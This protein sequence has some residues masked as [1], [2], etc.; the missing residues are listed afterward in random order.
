M[1]DLEHA[2][3]Q[4]GAALRRIARDLVGA[5][6]AEDV[7]QETALQALQA[8]SPAAGAR[9]GFLFTV[10]RRMAFRHRRARLRR[11]A[12]EAEVARD[13]VEH[14]EGATDHGEALRTLT[15]AVV[16][17][18]EPYRGAVYARY[19]QEQA[20]TAIAAALGVP[21]GTV[22]TRLK[23]GL[24]M[25]R[26]RLHARCRERGEDWRSGLVLAFALP[27]ATTST[28]SMAAAAAGGVVMTM[29]WK[30]LAAT[31]TVAALA[32]WFAMSPPEAPLWP[33]AADA[34]HVAAAAQRSQVADAD[35]VAAERV[36]PGAAAS[37][38][39]GDDTVAQAVTV[40]G[41]CV[42]AGGAPLGDVPISCFDGEE[43]GRSVAS[44]RTAVD[45]TFAWTT[46]SL[47]KGGELMLGRRGLVRR[48][49][50]IAAVV[51]PAERDLGDLV[52]A[53]ACHVLGRIVDAE[54]A[55]VP[56]LRIAFTAE[57]LGYPVGH[58]KAKS[59]G[60]FTLE[61][62]LP[63]GTYRVD[64]ENQRVQVPIV[65]LANSPDQ[66]VTVTLQRLGDEDMLRGVVVD[67]AGS[68]ISGALVLAVP[69]GTSPRGPAF[70]NSRGEF[71][72][73][74][75][76]EDSPMCS[77]TIAAEGYESPTGETTFAWGRQNIRIVLAR[78]GI[79]AIQV[80]RASDDTPVERFAVAFRAIEGLIVQGDFPAVEQHPQGIVTR[81]PLSGSQ[82]QV[83]LQPDDPRL[84]ALVANVPIVPHPAQPTILRLADLEPRRL[85]V[86]H[87]DGSPVP[88][89][90]VNVLMVCCDPSRIAIA[91]IVTV[92]H[93]PAG[94]LGGSLIVATTTT[95]EHGEA[96][97]QVPIGHTVD[98]QLVPKDR[99][100]A[101]Q[102]NL[103]LT[104]DAPLVVTL[105]GGATVRGRLGPDFIW[106][107]LRRLAGA[108]HDAT[109][110]LLPT[111][112]LRDP[113]QRAAPLGQGW[114]CSP[115]G[116][117]ERVGLP[118]GRW[119]LVVCVRSFA[120]LRDLEVDG[121]VLDLRD[122]TVTT[123]DVDLSRLQPGTLRGRV[124]RD[125][126]PVA[127]TPFALR[128]PPVEPATVAASEFRITTDGDGCFTITLPHGIWELRDPADPTMPS[129]AWPAAETRAESAIG[130]TTYQT[131]LLPPARPAAEKAR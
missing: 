122:D 51:A 29:T 80:V 71:Q 15:D 43:T 48:T 89:T 49:E 96:T 4:H 109:R 47:P 107:E 38:R 78:G 95:D 30:I 102:N 10:A 31:V 121:G 66:T 55:A 24:A 94:N 123:C 84:A 127:F 93:M 81:T 45:G 105:A 72:I 88:A 27:R 73:L 91:P 46:T 79:A 111:L 5:A 63:L 117:F 18:P 14:P 75:L 33:Q 2:L 92:D 83:L 129:D 6:D 23:R 20:P 113:D 97:V 37:P 103:A 58:G 39:T 70:S 98:L 35:Q 100:P 9:P 124:V 108:E 41:R 40:R 65:A 56:D 77:L 87:G 119:R 32:A 74:R 28:A 3:R 22:K 61:E 19:L 53:P 68:P 86:Q 57:P 42:D 54:G 36:A 90:V 120:G 101:R 12:R 67:E 52:L 110:V 34:A 82:C 7:V 60:S 115:D 118:A 112:T 21:V 11:L 85:R 16:A 13:P 99:A 114:S 104:P 62:G 26:E 125:G 25:L 69:P 130:Q 106:P 50:T 128:Q 59:D 1:D 126:K 8:P 131:F 116:T 64:V 17:L 76:P 44:L